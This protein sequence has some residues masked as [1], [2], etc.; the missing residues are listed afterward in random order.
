MVSNEHSKLCG[1]VSNTSGDGLAVKGSRRVRGRV[2]GEVLSGGRNVS[3]VPVRA[4]QTPRPGRDSARHHLRPE[5]KPVTLSES[6][7]DDCS[8]FGFED[9][10]DGLRSGAGT[11]SPSHDRGLIHQRQQEFNL[12]SYVMQAVGVA[13][14]DLGL[15]FSIAVAY[16]VFAE[17]FSQEFPFLRAV[18]LPILLAAWCGSRVGAN[19]RR[20]MRAGV[21]FPVAVSGAVLGSLAIG[22]GLYACG[23]FIGFYPTF[24]AFEMFNAPYELL[25]FSQIIDNGIGEMFML[26]RMATYALIPIFGALLGFIFSKR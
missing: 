11:S 3:G 16:A 23:R 26:F 19:A 20:R 13:A 10:W 24:M 25:E 22:A 8:D 18:L 4:R 21:I 5:P 17:I 7:Q 6:M 12:F 9:A 15:F 2:I 1:V 14:G